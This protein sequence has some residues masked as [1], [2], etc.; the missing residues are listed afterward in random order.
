MN[1][2]GIF[3]LSFPEA[4]TIIVSGDI[5]GNFNQLVFKL[6]IQYQLTDTLLIVAGDCGFGFEKKEYYEQIVRRNAKRMN[7]ANNWIVFVRGNHDNPAYFDGAMLNFKRFVAVPDYSI[8]CP[9][10]TGGPLRSNFSAAKGWW[11]DSE[12]STRKGDTI[13][14]ECTSQC[15]AYQ[16]RPDLLYRRDGTDA[17]RESGTFYT[18]VSSPTYIGTYAEACFIRA[19][20]LFNQ[21]NKG[22][23]FNAYKKGIAASIDG[24]NDKL[25]VWCREDANLEACPSFSPMT[26]TDIDNYLNNGIGTEENITLGKILTQKRLALHF[27]MEIWNDMRRYDFNPELFLGWGIP[28]R[29][30]VDATAQKN[31]P[32]GKQFRRWQQCS[33]ELNYNTANLQAIGATVPGADTSIAL[34]NAAEDVWTLPVWWDSAQN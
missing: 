18:R 24:M 31:I 27:S 28:A 22:A 26:Q 8:L 29:Y 30:G 10:L 16:G 2:N 25:K 19:E 21:G 23:A 14:V 7:Q 5:H 15:K 1:H 12:S 4:K 34:W 17:S 9:S 11:I 3:S 13:Y 32:Q 6:C 20:V 33:H